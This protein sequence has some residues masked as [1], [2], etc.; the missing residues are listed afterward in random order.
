MF[1]LVNFVITL[2]LCFIDQAMTNGILQ[3]IYGLAILLPGLGL[4]VRRLHDISKSG[5]WVLIAFIPVVGP[6]VLLILMCLNSPPGSNAYGPN[7][8]GL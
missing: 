3:I 5:W 7:P 8:K 6:I 4:T 2:V 1:A